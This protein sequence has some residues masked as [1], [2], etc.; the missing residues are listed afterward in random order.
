LIDWVKVL[1]HHHRDNLAEAFTLLADTGRLPYRSVLLK[2]KDIS[3]KY[4]E[5][6]PGNQRS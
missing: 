3:Q 1:L 4:G 6:A 2:N 5:S